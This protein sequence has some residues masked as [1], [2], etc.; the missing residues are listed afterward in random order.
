M[1]KLHYE[2]YSPSFSEDLKELEIFLEKYLPI[3]KSEKAVDA[4]DAGQ[5]NKVL[6]TFSPLNLPGVYDPPSVAAPE[7]PP[8]SL[9]SLHQHAEP[10]GPLT[11]RPSIVDTSHTSHMTTTSLHD[12]SYVSPFHLVQPQPVLVNDD[13]KQKEYQ[14]INIRPNDPLFSGLLPH[15]INIQI[16]IPPSDDR[17]YKESDSY[18]EE[19]VISEGPGY[20][21]ALGADYGLPPRLPS[22]SPTVTPGLPHYSP[23]PSTTAQPHLL[24]HHPPPAS[25][26]YQAGHHQPSYEP[27]TPA[28]IELPHT[29]HNLISDFRPP[30]A[31]YLG[32][33]SY[34]VFRKKHIYY[35]YFFDLKQMFNV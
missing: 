23:S 27:P 35:H 18:R 29:P 13:D 20:H 24:P 1:V 5:T 6:T 28:S 33:G 12:T 9:L 17:Q 14:E 2:K 30:H 10:A 19:K 8:D 11:D 4:G 21:S 26:H 32:M 34:K 16:N 3:L 25:S 31:E 15:A 22:Y 7:P